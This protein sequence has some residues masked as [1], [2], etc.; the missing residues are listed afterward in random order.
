[1]AGREPHLEAFRHVLNEVSAHRSAALPVLIG[2]GGSGRSSTL[3]A[4]AE[5]ASEQ[6]WLV[7]SVTADPSDPRDLRNLLAGAAADAVELMLARRPGSPLAAPMAKAV[8][9]YHAATGNRLGIQAHGRTLVKDRGNLLADTLGLFRG[10]SLALHD[11]IGRGLMIVVDDAH[12][13][14]PSDLDVLLASGASAT[15]RG[16][17]IV[18]AMAGSPQL[19]WRTQVMLDGLRCRSVVLTHLDPDQTSLAVRETFAR[20]GR[21]VKNDALEHIY[22][23][24]GGHPHFVQMLGELIW[25][26][27]PRSD[28]S[29]PDVIEAASGLMDR[30]DKHVLAPRFARLDGT[31]R[32]L[33]RAVADLPADAPPTVDYLMRRIGTATRFGKSDGSVEVAQHAL[34]RQGLVFSPD[35][36]VVRLTDHE[37]RRYALATLT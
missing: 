32:R 21:T 26:S 35:G 34:V 3:A 1:M 18:I 37:V 30:Y 23:V 12:A 28:V 6:G 24:T 19:L 17:P 14:S 33:V 9:G 11:L 13:L 22:R 7:A 36:I 5:R 8:A 20:A 31:M 25:D 27:T 2:D 4:V 16:A 29:L 15:S 10:L